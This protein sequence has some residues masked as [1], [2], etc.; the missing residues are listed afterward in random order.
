MADTNDIII[1]LDRSGSMEARKADHEGG[2]RSFV[3]DSRDLPGDNRLSFI[4]F[5]HLNACDVILNRAPIKEVK[6]EALT[7]IPRGGTP[8]L[9]AV[10]QTLTKYAECGPGTI[11]MIITDGQEN[12]STT[13]KKEPVQALVK[14][15]EGRGWKVLYL[16]ANVDE[17]AEAAAMGVAAGAAL[18]YAA[19]RRG[20][21]AMYAVTSA[22]VGATLSARAQGQSVN[23]SNSNLDWTAQ[24]R[25]TTAGNKADDGHTTENKA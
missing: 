10:G 13:W 8:L 3:R 11:M 1:L 24:Q 16:G 4:L 15:R 12:Q 18:N 9:D 6:E 23:Q 2:L 14:E 25:S 20:T 7:L 22:N 5:D 21:S 17:F 19:T